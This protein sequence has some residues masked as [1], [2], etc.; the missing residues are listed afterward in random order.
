MSSLVIDVSDLTGDP[1]ATKE[2]KTSESIA[3]LR[4]ALGYVDQ[5]KPLH[6]ELLAE[7]VVD[8]IAVS[9]QVGGTMT[10]VC[11]RCLAEFEEPLEMYV[12]EVFAFSATAKDEDAYQVQGKTIDLEP[13]LRDLTILAIP[14]R[15]LHSDAC[16]GICPVCG[17]DRN[18]V[19]CGHREEKVELRW[20]PLRALVESKFQSE[21]S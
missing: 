4:S 19:D 16:K 18:Q 17:T 21:E 14:I 11:S 8:G 5:S 7:S 3:G 20:E 6:L 15:P 2:I 13:M 10:L 1:G 9:G 12:D